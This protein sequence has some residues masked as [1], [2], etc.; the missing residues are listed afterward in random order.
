MP[1]DEH[2]TPVSNATAMSSFGIWS[3]ERERSVP[4]VWQRVTM[5]GS[6]T[7]K[8][9]DQH[10]LYRAVDERK[11]QSYVLYTLD[12]DQL[13]FIQF[14]LGGLTK[15]EVRE[16]ARH[17]DLPVA[18]KPE[19]QEICFVGDR[20]YAEFV[21]ER[22]PDVTKPGNIVDTAGVTIGQH[23]G[24]VRHTIGQRRGIGIP[25]EKPL[26]VLHLDTGQNQ[27]VVGSREEAI[28]DS[29]RSEDVS[30]TSGEWPSEPIECEVS[31]RYRGRPTRSRDR[32]RVRL[33]GHRAVS[34]RRTDR[35]TGAS[36]RLLSGR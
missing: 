4:T 8:S 30:F 27:L 13:S 19:S 29:L 16:I 3:P 23:Q 17:F 31:V 25:R 28:A 11:D 20:S 26:F 24:L 18:D 7:P 14:P 36:D 22:R 1:R 34:R 12:Q 21:A 15:P 2:Q 35:R 9:G 5:P 6:F 32:V 33:R 10:R